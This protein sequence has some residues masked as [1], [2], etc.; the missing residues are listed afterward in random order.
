MLE[1][2]M[3][4]G[5]L[6]KWDVVASSV[7][8]SASATASVNFPAG[9]QAGDAILAVV[10]SNTGNLA[11]KS[12]PSGWEKLGELDNSNFEG[13]VYLLPKVVAQTAFQNSNFGAST[14]CSFILVALRP[15]NVPRDSMVAGLVYNKGEASGASSTPNP[16]SISTNSDRNYIFAVGFQSGA[17]VTAFSAP[18]GYSI[19]AQASG[20]STPSCGFVAKADAL[21]ESAGAADPGTF[22]GPSAANWYG[23]TFSLR[24]KV[25]PGLF[26]LSASAFA[27]ETT[28]RTDNPVVASATSVTVT[29]EGGGTAN[30][31]ISGGNSA[32]YRKN[33]GSWTASSGTVSNGDVVEVRQTALTGTAGTTTTAT[34]TLTI[35]SASLDY[36]LSTKRFFEKTD[37]GDSS[38]DVPTGIT[39]VSV[40]GTGGGGGGGSYQSDIDDSG[41]GGGGGGA[42]SQTPSLAV[43]P[44]ETLVVRRGAG[45]TYSNTENS[46]G[47]AGG[48]S[49][50]LRSGS[51]IW[52][53]KGGGGGAGGG[54]RTGGSGGS[55][56][57]SI[58]TTK[59][60]GGNG[61]NGAASYS[62]SNGG[63]GGGGAGGYSGAG[64]NGAAG[65]SS[66]G[67]NLSSAG[68]GGAAS[69]GASRYGGGG[70]GVSGSG[71]SGAATTSGSPN[72]KEGSP[73]AIASSATN[74]T[75]GL[76]G[77]GGAGGGTS[78]A[79]GGPGGDGAVRITW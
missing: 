1:L 78:S 44:G 16:P 30:I 63:G 17:N 51:P 34:A 46:T 23:L 58:G 69:G 2:L 60:A 47:G 71:T 74:Q 59:Y 32:Q 27:S 53:A 14:D 77:G 21:Q 20:A 43:T 29:L 67:Q 4:G 6:G 8:K 45:G 18:S 3:G 79:A 15:T 22:T 5:G 73:D 28:G 9:Y 52:R 70:T 57:N 49:E 62:S 68:T 41:G 36:S 19:I 31:S 72:G 75:G 42:M 37:A 65:A 38:F 26:A 40:V 66:A 25:T 39:S 12:V 11:A 54:S 61:G 56:T 10:V 55:A 76:S 13:C 64:S 48:D 33:G 50:I 24:S 35:G 7:T